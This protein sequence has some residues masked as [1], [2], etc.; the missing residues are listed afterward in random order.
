MVSAFALLTIRE[1]VS[2]MMIRRAL[3][4]KFFMLQLLL[5]SFSIL[6]MTAMFFDGEDALHESLVRSETQ[7]FIEKYLQDSS[8]PLP[9]TKNILSF[10]GRDHIPKKYQS[11]ISTLEPGIFELDL[12]GL[13][14][15]N[16]EEEIRV[17]VAPIKE[18]HPYFYLISSIPDA[19]GEVALQQELLLLLLTYVLTTGA[20]GYWLAWFFSK[21]LSQPIEN[22]ATMVNA[23]KDSAPSTHLSSIQDEGEIGVLAKAIDQKNNRISQFIQREQDVM[24]NIRHE[25]R[26]PITILKSSIT[27]AKIDPA[28]DQYYRVD[29][30][31]VEKIERASTDLEEITD[32]FLWLGKEVI[33]PH[34]NA[35]DCAPYIDKAI[36][37][38]R[39]LLNQKP[40]KLI[41]DID[42][43]ATI[44]CKDTL[45]YIVAS[46]LLRNAFV[47]TQTGQIMITLTKK[48]LSVEDSGPGIAPEISHQLK[49]SG[50][51]SDSSTGFGFGLHITEQ[52]CRRLGWQL[53]LQPSPRTQGTI[54]TLTWSDKQLDENTQKSDSGT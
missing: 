21:N 50:I 18:G 49:D 8:T 3:F 38:H 53:T 47:F 2:T 27:L 40:V 33:H 19:N 25:L 46:N 42:A 34:K 24:R 30:S 20:L 17:V 36:N 32:A 29:T 7:Y 4:R 15:F 43:N 35:I 16:A 5:F 9:Q 28:E 48:T 1:R 23:A 44:H 54:A 12:E 13:P 31:I 11:L 26:T 51:K 6:F 14:E 37:N 10:I 45:F 41:F 22:M 52:I 39:Y